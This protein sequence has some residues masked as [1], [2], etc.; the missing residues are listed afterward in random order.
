MVAAVALFACRDV[1]VYIGCILAVVFGDCN[2]ASTLA[3]LEP[4]VIFDGA[5]SL[6]RRH[7][8]SSRSIR[9]LTCASTKVH[10]HT[11]SSRTSSNTRQ[12]SQDPAGKAPCHQ[13][14]EQCTHYNAIEISVHRGRTYETSTV[15]VN[16][17]L[18]F[19]LQLP[20]LPHLPHNV[21]AMANVLAITNSHVVLRLEDWASLCSAI[22]TGSLD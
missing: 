8:L 10:T 15:A 3:H 13:S 2:L 16:S 21:H 11:R 1:F 9:C 18:S 17:P 12:H 20:Q 5:L 19:S 22:E 14:K 6:R 4:S 7:Y